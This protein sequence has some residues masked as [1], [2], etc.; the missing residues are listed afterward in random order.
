[1]VPELMGRARLQEPT[2]AAGGSG[3][4]RRGQRKTRGRGSFYLNEL[5]KVLIA[6]YFRNSF[7]INNEFSSGI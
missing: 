7:P 6:F 1:M 2:A 5:T 3:R 4:R